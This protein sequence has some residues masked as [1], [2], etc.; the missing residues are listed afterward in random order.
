ML[1]DLFI[2]GSTLPTGMVIMSVPNRPVYAS[3]QAQ[4][5]GIEPSPEEKI[6]TDPRAIK[7]MENFANSLY[8]LPSFSQAMDMYLK[9][10]S[11]VV[12][13]PSQQDELMKKADTAVET[14]FKQEI[15]K[16]K[17]YQKIMDQIEALGQNPEEHP[18]FKALDEKLQKR[19]KYERKLVMHKMATQE[20]LKNLEASIL[21]A[22]SGMPQPVAPMVPEVAV[23]Q[24]VKQLASTIG[25]TP[26]V[27]VGGAGIGGA[28]VGGAGVGEFHVPMDLDSIEV[29]QHVYI[30]KGGQKVLYEV[31]KKPDTAEGKFELANLKLVGGELKKQGG[32]TKKVKLG[33]IFLG[34][35]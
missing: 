35:A 16:D 1:T 30:D 17:Q 18:E 2:S 5:V 34:P 29:D 31:V 24:N 20:G 8:T 9:Q 15:E 33:E 3:S 14:Y 19:F 23:P 6:R 32:A 28:G 21:S 27:A 26:A 4:Y 25:A 13:A 11:L 7:N 10:Q 22:I 12:E